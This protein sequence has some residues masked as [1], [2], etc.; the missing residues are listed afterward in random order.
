MIL[1][2]RVNTQ[3]TIAL[4]VALFA[5]FSF[6]ADSPASLPIAS[7]LP[8]TTVQLKAEPNAATITAEWTNTIRWDSQRLVERLDQSC[9]CLS[10]SPLSPASDTMEAKRNYLSSP[11]SKYKTAASLKLPR[12]NASSV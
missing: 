2:V 5:P 10:A 11:C 1:A 9:S 7:G 8:A 12:R 6:A 4:G 3:R